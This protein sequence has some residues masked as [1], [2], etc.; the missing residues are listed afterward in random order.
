MRNKV[1]KSIKLISNNINNSPI[2][3]SSF[4]K[5]S[6]VMLD[7]IKKAGHKLPIMFFK[8]PF[9][10]KK[11]E[12]ANKI[13]LENDYVVYDY[14]PITTGVSK[15]NGRLEIIN[16]YQLYSDPLRTFYLPTGFVDYEID[17]PFLCGLR[18]IID[19]PKGNI[20]DFMWDTIFIGHKSSDKD[21]VLGGIVTLDDY[22][23][24]DKYSDKTFVFPL[25]DFTDEDIWNYTKENNLPY[26]DKR[27]DSSNNFKE[28][29]DVTYNPDRYPTCVAC[30]DRDNPKKIV[31]PKIGEVINNVSDTIDYIEAD[32]SHYIK[33]EEAI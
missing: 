6:M 24:T 10:P 3:M 22:K 20:F 32:L 12:F 7:L 33:V 23:F 11:F 19:R 1:N 30:I 15:R 28:F 17:K 18:D 14:L 26:N 21:L 31:C 4:G 13:I 16:L 5:D 29:K 8:E 27:Y 2:V 25:R 9:F